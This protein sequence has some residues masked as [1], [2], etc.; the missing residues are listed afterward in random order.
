M[1]TTWCIYLCH[2]HPQEC[3][4]VHNTEYK[5]E[6]MKDKVLWMQLGTGPGDL[7]ETGT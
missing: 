7:Q 1:Q 6:Y 4:E 2:W 5:T 3:L